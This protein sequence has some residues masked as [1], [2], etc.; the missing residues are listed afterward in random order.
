MY[1][2]MFFT[3]EEFPEIFCLLNG[4]TAFAQ[5]LQGYKSLKKCT[6]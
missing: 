5:Q 3:I 6:D 4:V 1:E 2:I